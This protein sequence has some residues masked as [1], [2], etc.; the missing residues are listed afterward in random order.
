[1]IRDKIVIDT[2]NHQ[3]RQHL[4]CEKDLTSQNT[5]DMCTLAQE[6]HK[7]AKEM[8]VPLFATAGTSAE[9]DVHALRTRYG[10]TQSNKDPGHSADRKPTKAGGRNCRKCGTKHDP[11]QCPAYGQRGPTT[12]LPCVEL[13]KLDCMKSTKEMRQKI[14]TTSSMISPTLCILATLTVV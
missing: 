14:R 1:M 9:N 5:I 11:K 10:K 3:L 12:T 4:L 6:S 2:K 8:R 7:Q 13:I